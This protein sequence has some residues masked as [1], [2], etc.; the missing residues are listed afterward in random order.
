MKLRP[1]VR[2]MS[3][4]LSGGIERHRAR[5]DDAGAGDQEQR[6]VEPDLEAAQ[7]HGAAF[8]LV[9][10]SFTGCPCASAA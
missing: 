4:Q 9:P 10:Q 8:N 5:F 7:F 1:S 2:Q 3:L 6:L